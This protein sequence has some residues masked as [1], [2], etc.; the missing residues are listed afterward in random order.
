MTALKTIPEA[1]SVLQA[2]HLLPFPGPRSIVVMDNCSTH[3]VKEVQEAIYTTG[4]LLLYLLTYSP[5]L[6]PVR[7]A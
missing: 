1:V 3:H 4:A 5:E 2:P 7:R 6:N